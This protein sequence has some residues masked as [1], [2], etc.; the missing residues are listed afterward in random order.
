MR[1]MQ[2][3]LSTVVEVEVEV[4]AELGKKNAYMGGEESGIRLNIFR[5]QH[6]TQSANSRHI[7]PI[8]HIFL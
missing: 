3:Q 1:I 4:E 7:Q 8:H 2:T 6:P 5:S